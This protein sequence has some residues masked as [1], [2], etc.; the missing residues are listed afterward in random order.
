MD[1]TDEYEGPWPH[2]GIPLPLGTAPLEDV[3][4]SDLPSTAPIEDVEIS[5]L[6]RTGVDVV[7]DIKV[8]DQMPGS[9]LFPGNLLNLFKRPEVIEGY[10]TT[11][12]D[13]PVE[14]PETYD[15]LPMAP[16]DDIEPLPFDEGREDYIRRQNEYVSPPPVFPGNIRQDPQD[17]D[18]Y[19]KW[20]MSE[21]I[22]YGSPNPQGDF[23]KFHEYPYPESIP[24]II[25]YNDSAR[26]AGIMRAMRAPYTRENYSLPFPPRGPH[27]PF[28]PDQE[29]FE[30]REEYD[31]W[32]RRQRLGY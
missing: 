10:D 3:E 25:P 14:E 29:M 7:D 5:D 1:F 11:Y 6:P 18:K 4:I 16:P 8:T 24:P 19:L 9:W 22:P 2:E 27:D 21:Q 30:N 20:L 23:D 12:I 31:A 26:E 17:T 28:D 32:R 15:D 13:E